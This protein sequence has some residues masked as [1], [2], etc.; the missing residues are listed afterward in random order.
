MFEI[1]K[2]GP[3]LKK[4]KRLKVIKIKDKNAINFKSNKDK[5]QQYDSIQNKFNSNTVA[6]QIYYKGE[7]E[8]E[9]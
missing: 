5:Q 4:K 2:L 3:W 9:K 1:S 8:F 7:N 6:V